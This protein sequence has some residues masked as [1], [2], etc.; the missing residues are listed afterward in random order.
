MESINAADFSRFAEIINRENA[1]I[2]KDLEVIKEKV[3]AVD[4]M[5]K[6]I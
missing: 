6:D 2:R 5:M 1:E 4:K 3:E